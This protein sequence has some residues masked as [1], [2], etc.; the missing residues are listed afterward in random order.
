SETMAAL[1]DELARLIG[2]FHCRSPLATRLL[3]RR[4][5]PRREIRGLRCEARRL[6]SEIFAFRAAKP[7]KGVQRDRPAPDRNPCA[8]RGRRRPFRSDAAAAHIGEESGVSQ[9][10]GRFFALATGGFRRRRFLHPDK[11]VGV[12]SRVLE[13]GSNC[14]SRFNNAAYFLDVYHLLIGPKF[15]SPLTEQRT[16]S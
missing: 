10:R 5:C 13:S 9:L 12:R 11:A 8:Q 14:P 15:A 1:A 16:C 3:A 7:L 6:R 2:S 4:F